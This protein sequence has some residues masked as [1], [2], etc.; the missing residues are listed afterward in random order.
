MWITQA[1]YLPIPFD[2][3]NNLRSNHV[4]ED[5]ERHSGETKAPGA[6]LVKERT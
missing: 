4:P 1:Y 6:L 2:G 3:M 5:G